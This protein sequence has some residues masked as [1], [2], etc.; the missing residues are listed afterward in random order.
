APVSLRGRQSGMAT[1][2]VRPGMFGK[3][4]Q[5]ALRISRPGDRILLSPGQYAVDAFSMF[6]LT[7]RGTG[8]PSE[9]V[10][11]TKIEVTG[12]ARLESLTLRA[13]HFTNAMY[14]PHQGASAQLTRCI[15]HAD[16]SEKYP[17]LYC[18]GSS[19]S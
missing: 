3:T 4:L 5:E 15:V 13:P 19:L 2:K 6:D 7:I 17:A 11:E 9:V 12:R 8:D 18:A 1:I 10:L 16:P 14:M